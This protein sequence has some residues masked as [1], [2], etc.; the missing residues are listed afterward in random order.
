L[1]LKFHTLPPYVTIT[2]I[3]FSALVLTYGFIFIAN[4]I[5]FDTDA[6]AHY[7]IAKELVINPFNFG[8]NWVW[9]PLYHYLLAFAIKLHLSFENIRVF[10]LLIWVVL[11]IVLFYYLRSQAQNKLSYI[12]LISFIF[13]ISFP[14]GM[15]YATSAQYETFFVLLLILFIVFAERQK[16]FLSSVFLSMAVLTRY[17]AWFVLIISAVYFLIKYVRSRQVIYL[18]QVVS[19]TFLPSVVI[20]GWAFLRLP[21]D[22]RFF[23]F[24]FETKEFVSGA[25]GKLHP[26]VSDTIKWYDFFYYMLY[27]PFL[28]MTINLVFVF[29]GIKRVWKEYR[30]LFLTGIA[31]ILFISLSYVIKTNLGLFRH[32]IPALIIYSVLGGAGIEEVSLFLKRKFSGTYFI[33]KFA[34]YMVVIFVVI[35]LSVVL[36][37]GYI[38]TQT[39][40]EGFPDK[41][42]IADF[43]K[44]LPASS[45]ILTNDAVVKVLSGLPYEQ[46]DNYWLSGDEKTF[47]Y[48]Y[49]L[50]KQKSEVYIIV[51]FEE[52]IPYSNIG[53]IKK[54]SRE[55]PKTHQKLTVLEIW[56][57]KK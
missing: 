37:W 13:S 26:S 55:N 50:K 21:Y 54:I 5:D 46:F 24:I 49:E 33:P 9:L 57:E 44:T 53:N 39:Y 43:L 45:K 27:I 42:E 52:L 18:K 3:V 6:Y 47:S 11:N 23:G 28:M 40:K 22:G 2:L 25:L 36:Y 16:Y 10:N 35:Q 34:N 56:N 41:E 14:I 1:K 15:V 29:F 30:F 7:I 19:I 32:F 8:I 17:E 31:V 20:L 4:I 38:W 12:P 48:L 51:P